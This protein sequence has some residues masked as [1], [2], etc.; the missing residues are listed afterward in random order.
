MDFQAGYYDRINGK[1]YRAEEAQEMSPDKLRGLYNFLYATEEQFKALE[2]MFSDVYERGCAAKDEL[3]NKISE[4]IKM[5]SPLAPNYSDE[6][7]IQAEQD[8]C[9]FVKEY[10]TSLTNAVYCA[11]SNLTHTVAIADN[12][13]YYLVT[14]DD[15]EDRSAFS[16]VITSSAE[17][18]LSMYP[19]NADVR[20]LVEAYGRDELAASLNE[21]INEIIDTAKRDEKQ[22]VPDTPNIKEKV[23]ALNNK[24]ENISEDKPPRGRNN[25]EL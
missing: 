7:I 14:L 22:P 24:A 17:E 18:L 9:A 16:A 1:C 5:T 21:F 20:R 11:G 8:V 25:P 3:S 2:K 15:T 19:D 6:Q 10:E 12:G 23:E 4:Y 13:N